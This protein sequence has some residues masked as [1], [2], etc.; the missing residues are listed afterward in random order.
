MQRVNELFGKEV[1]GRTTGEKLGTVRDIVF[2]GEARGIVALLVGGTLSRD[3]V[4]RWGSVASLGDV[5]VVGD[6]A[7]LEKAGDDREVRDLRKRGYK[8]TGTDIYT[9]GGEKIGTVHDLFVNGLGLVAGYEVGRG[10][11][12][13]LAGRKFLPIEQVRANGKDAIIVRDGAGLVSVKG[14][15]KDRS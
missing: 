5:V 14:V 6:D 9:E 4:V 2:D 3:R 15:E 10:V 8:I 12:S 7:P 11:V 13:D 1:V